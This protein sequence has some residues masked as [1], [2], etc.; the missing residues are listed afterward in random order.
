VADD[1]FRV[2]AVELINPLIFETIHYS[3]NLFKS[4]KIFREAGKQ[5]KFI[6][7]LTAYKEIINR[8]AEKYQ[9]RNPGGVPVTT[10]ITIT[11]HEPANK[12]HV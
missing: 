11:E 8:A 4:G 10:T 5:L 1:I 6:K 2:L 3:L 9:I 12:L 7:E